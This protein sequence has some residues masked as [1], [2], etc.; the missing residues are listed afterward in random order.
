MEAMREL[1]REPIIDLCHFGVP[2]WLENFQNP[3]VPHALRDYARD[4][5]RRYPWVRF[6][7]PVN[8]LFVCAKLSALEGV[9]NEQRR[10]ERSFVTAVTHLAKIGSASGRER[11]CL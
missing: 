11:G 1:A 3:E 7:T 5:A 10:D 8:E 9:W 2:N 4:F 6:Y